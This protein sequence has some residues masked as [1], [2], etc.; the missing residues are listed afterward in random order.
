MKISDP[1]AFFKTTPPILTTPPYLKSPF[2]QKFQK[3]E[4]PHILLESWKLTSYVVLGY[5]FE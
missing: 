5:D 1:T 3:T 4:A 2:F